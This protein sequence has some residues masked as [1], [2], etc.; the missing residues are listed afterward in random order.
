MAVTIKELEALES[1]W[2]E[3]QREYGLD[4]KQIAINLGYTLVE[5]QP[6]K[7]KKVL[8]TQPFFDIINT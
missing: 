5:E 6:K 1:G 7:L 8:T 3:V 4:D 2:V